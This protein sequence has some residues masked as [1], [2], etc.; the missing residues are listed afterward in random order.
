MAL[1]YGCGQRTKVDQQLNTE[2]GE[3]ARCCRHDCQGIVQGLKSTRYCHFFFIPLC[4][5]GAES[6]VKCQVCGSAY[7]A[8][9]Y[10]NVLK[11]AGQLTAQEDPTEASSSS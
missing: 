10:K 2:I 4:N 8:D 7:T 9:S 3:A 11:Q 5:Y 6:Y 1:I